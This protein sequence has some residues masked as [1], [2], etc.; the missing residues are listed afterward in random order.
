F[1]K[2]GDREFQR[3]AGKRLVDSISLQ[4]DLIGPVNADEFADLKD[5]SPDSVNVLAVALSG[6]GPTK[7]A[8]RIGPIP[9]GTIPLYFELPYLRSHPSEAGNARIEVEGGDG[10]PAQK[11][12]LKFVEDLSAV[13]TENHRRAMPV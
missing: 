12:S 4:K 1:M 3:V 8:Q 6:R 10:V 2:S 7:Y 9:L 13:A 11:L 5:I